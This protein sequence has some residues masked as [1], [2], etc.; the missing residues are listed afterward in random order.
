MI[1]L[2]KEVSCS[3]TLR[4]FVKNFYMLFILYALFCRRKRLDFIHKRKYAKNAY[5]CILHAF[6]V[7][8][9]LSLSGKNGAAHAPFQK[10]HM[11]LFKKCS[12]VQLNNKGRRKCTS[13]TSVNGGLA[14]PVGKT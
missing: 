11:H 13:G 2:V 12:A 6:L 1:F 8:S 14:A 9:H 5:A 10:K 7:H 4:S 3:V